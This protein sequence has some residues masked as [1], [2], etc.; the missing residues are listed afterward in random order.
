MID[1]EGN[2]GKHGTENGNEE[3]C[4]ENRTEK[5]RRV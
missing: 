5:E 1:W 2:E 4:G 3:Y